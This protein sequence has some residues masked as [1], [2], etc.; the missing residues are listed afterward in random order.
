[1]APFVYVTDLHGHRWRYEQAF[2]LARE[3][4]ADLLVNGG[5]LLPHGRVHDEQA[6]FIG[7]FLDPYFA[8]CAR[9]G[10]RCV[11]IPGNDDLAAH[12]PLLDT[13]CGRHP[14]VE[15]VA[16][17]L[18]TVGSC[19]VGGLDLVADFPFRLKDRARMDT[20]DAAFPPQSSGGLLSVPGGWREIP[21]WPA[22]ARTLPTIADE[23]A[24][25]PAPRDPG[26]AVYLLHGPPADRGLDVCRGGAAVGS[27]AVL[28]FLERVQPRLAL[29]GHIHES[30]QES[31]AWKAAVGRTVCIQ[32]GQAPGSLTAVVGSLDG[33]TFERV[34]IPEGRP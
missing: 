24:A 8:A 1:M 11:V 32:P 19:D 4:G 33:M 15:I 29:H 21:D 7:E 17:R 20:R 2:A 18:A 26:R 6:R 28:A 34:V 27:R 23:L 13:V 14:H 5:D 30:P 3:A 31:G 10:I 12:D 9:H 16:R 22:Y 25:L